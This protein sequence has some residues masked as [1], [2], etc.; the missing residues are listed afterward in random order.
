[1]MLSLMGIVVAC[2]VSAATY[3]QAPYLG[4]TAIQT[5]QKF[6]T[7]FA[8]DKVFA[9]NPKHY[10][11]M[12]GFR[13]NSILGIEAGYEWQ[14]RIN[15][16]HCFLPGETTHT[17]FVV[18]PLQTVSLISQYEGKH[19]YVGITGRYVTPIRLGL[20]ILQLEGFVGASFSKVTAHQEVH[21]VNDLVH[22]IVYRTYSQ[23]YIAPMLKIT[24]LVD[25]TP[26]FNL[27]LTLQ[28]RNMHGFK[29]TSAPKAVSDARQTIQM[30]DMLG[31][32]LLLR[33]HF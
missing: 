1:M 17:G 24:A 6:D 5:N 20:N 28:Y 3:F 29:L 31:I 15:K 22:D 32:G 14:P 11:V 13:F 16:R 19:P 4:I 33:L 30:K 25:L 21:D 2:S 10:G 27:G 7:K 18:D 12:A 8:G 23:H 9:R 26:Y